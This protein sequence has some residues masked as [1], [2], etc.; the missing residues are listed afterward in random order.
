MSQAIRVDDIKQIV[1][2]IESLEEEK[3]EIS[4]HIKDAYL[5]AKSKGYDV[6]ILKSVIKLRKKDKDKIAEE[7]DL[8]EV[9]RQALGI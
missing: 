3:K 1:S 4:D 9:Y 7:D 2:K 5:E 6:K 8:T